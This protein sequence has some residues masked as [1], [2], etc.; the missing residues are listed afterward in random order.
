MYS[1]SASLI[2]LSPILSFFFN[3]VET[4]HIFICRRVVCSASLLHVPRYSSSTGAASSSAPAASAPA[5]SAAASAAA[6]A[7]AAS[8][9]ACSLP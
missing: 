6:T 4:A 8:N 3:T 9:S 1:V 7:A 2:F 5:A